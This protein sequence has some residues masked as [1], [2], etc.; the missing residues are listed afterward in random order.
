VID[1]SGLS[2]LFNVGYSPDNMAA[3]CAEHEII[4]NAYGLISDADGADRFVKF[5]TE[6]APEHA[7]F[8]AVRILALKAT[9]SC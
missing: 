9:I 8:I 3:L 5:A 1:F 6:N 4:S 2:G 7:P